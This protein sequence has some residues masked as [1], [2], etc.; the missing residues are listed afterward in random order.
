MAGAIWT[1]HKSR[2][3]DLAAVK[4]SNAAWRAE[5]GPRLAARDREQAAIRDAG[6]AAMATLEPEVREAIER[7]YGRP[8]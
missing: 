5:H 6:R 4:A 1:G 7:A 8:L 3:Y 2:P